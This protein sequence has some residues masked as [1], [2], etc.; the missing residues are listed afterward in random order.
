MFN[1]TDI[2]CHAL[3]RID[4]GA[5]N[6][7][8]MKNMLD[9]AYSDGIRKIC[10]T[11]HFKIFEFRNDNDINTY[12]TLTKQIF[13]IAV[14]YVKEKYPD[15]SLFLGNEVMYHS[16]FFSSLSKK[17]YRTLNNSLYVLVEFNPNVSEFDLKNGIMRILRKGFIPLLAHIERYGVLIKNFNLLQELKQMGE[18]AEKIAIKYMMIKKF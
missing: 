16:D 12:N 10:F 8:M 9:I 14:E 18:K 13:S 11:P 6:S 7:S 3:S 15:M 4:D 2:H 5:E 1:L 17:H